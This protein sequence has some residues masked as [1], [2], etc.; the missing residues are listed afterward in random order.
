M[1]N[2]QNYA[3]HLYDD[4]KQ[5]LRASAERFG[6]RA[7]LLQKR[8]RHFHATCYRRFAADVDALGTA[9]LCRGWR[10]RRVL[11]LG[12][13]ST[14][15]ATAYMAL[16]CG[17][18]TV[19][20]ID[21]KL[22]TREIVRLAQKVGAEAIVCPDARAPKLRA[23]LPALDLLPLE[24]LPDKIA[25][26]YRRIREGDRAYLDAAIDPDAL[27][28]VVF[29]SGSTDRARA[30][31]L[32]HRNLCFALAE[33]CKMVYIDEEDL[34]LSVLPMHHVYE[35][36]CGFLCPL[37]RGAAVAFSEGF[38]RLTQELREVRPTV[39]LCVPLLTELLYRNLCTHIRRL[40]LASRV[41][42]QI[43]L[44]DSIPQREARVAAK[45][46][47]FASIHRFFGGRLRLIVSGGDRVDPSCLHGLRALG[48]TALQG[49]GM[50]ECAALIALNRDTYPNDLAAGM[51]TPRTLIDVFEAEE[52][53]IGEIRFKGDNLMLGYLDDPEQTARAVRGGWLHTG[54][55][56]MIDDE[57]FLY[58]IGRVE[59]IIRVGGKK[60][61][62]EELEE[63][64]CKN[65]YVAE[66][67][68]IGHKTRGQKNE[69]IAVIY[70]DPARLA[71]LK[72]RHG[73][74]AEQV[75]ELEL[76]RALSEV[77]GAVLPHK[78]L[79]GFVL[80]ATPFEKNV[81]GKLLRRGVAE[82][83]VRLL[84]GKK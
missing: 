5:L 4:L 16:I 83:A 21:C 63:R 9:L 76:R 55:L 14:E 54:D 17:V 22:R 10:G 53:G 8:D 74:L 41:A 2:Y 20:P 39:M 40:G 84:K 50:T 69:P 7:L 80:R 58:V 77:N 42:L 31:M 44:T 48:F 28:T 49:Y 32:S 26:G 65:R 18:G 57:G 59:N 1:P 35:T 27:C 81:A 71:A 34:F 46:K 43:K 24:S 12:E 11:L 79:A 75:L 13:N 73:A 67:V 23:A 70:P 3:T 61:Y 47:I 66:A 68:V 15:W 64:L 52:D 30:V 25:D 19:I 56:G 78:R 36:V 72:R 82:Q 60:V 62:P 6:E 45:R 51:S 33:M 37:Y 38:D 29:T